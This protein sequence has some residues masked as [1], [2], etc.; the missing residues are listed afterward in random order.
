MGKK[1]NPLLIQTQIFS[2]FQEKDLSLASCS[3]HFALF[4][5][6]LCLHGTVLGKCHVE[7]ITE[8]VNTVG[9]LYPRE[10]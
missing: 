1:P 10:L 5:D 4:I 6:L 7:C 3:L 8:R 9:I 2:Y